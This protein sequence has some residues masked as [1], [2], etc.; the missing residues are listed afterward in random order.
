MHSGQGAALIMSVG[1][2]GHSVPT[3]P[4]G[5]RKQRLPLPRL[6]PAVGLLFPPPRPLPTGPVV[7][8][9]AAAAVARAGAGGP[10]VPPEERRRAAVPAGWRMWALAQRC[11]LARS[12]TATWVCG[13]VEGALSVISH[14]PV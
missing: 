8:A 13:K 14:P 12:S 4:P 1:E 5:K 6:L 11:S 7:R 10:A 9:T 2:A 3:Y